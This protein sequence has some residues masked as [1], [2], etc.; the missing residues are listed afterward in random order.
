MGER[1]DTKERFG[2]V[3][4]RCERHSNHGGV[5]HT[6]MHK[7]LLCTVVMMLNNNCNSKEL[8]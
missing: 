4:V 5:Y 2:L 8:R 3:I 6:H 1:D 7:K